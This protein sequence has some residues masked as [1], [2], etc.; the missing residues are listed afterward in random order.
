M[1]SEGSA[2]TKLGLST[3]NPHLPPNAHILLAP[4]P[5]AFYLFVELHALA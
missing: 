5:R 1:F 3:S 2:N 4:A